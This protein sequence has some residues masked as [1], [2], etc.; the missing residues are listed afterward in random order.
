MEKAFHQIPR[1]IF[2]CV[3]AELGVEDGTV[4]V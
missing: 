3:L 2:W 4:K 1:D